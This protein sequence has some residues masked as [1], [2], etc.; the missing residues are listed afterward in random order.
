MFVLHNFSFVMSPDLL[1]QNKVYLYLGSLYSWGC[2]FKCG[3]GERLSL[4]YVS[5]RSWVCCWFSPCFKAVSFSSYS[6]FR[7]LRKNQHLQIP[8]RLE[9][10]R[11]DVA[12]YLPIWIFKARKYSWINICGRSHKQRLSRQILSSVCV[13]HFQFTQN[14]ANKM[15]WLSYRT[16]VFRYT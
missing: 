6:G 11:T 3:A 2:G 7:P 1:S 10:A 4:T 15:Q 16:T 9:P 8:N 12:S 5:Y 13:G 14:E